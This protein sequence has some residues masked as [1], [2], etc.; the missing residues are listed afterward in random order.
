MLGKSGYFP[1]VCLM[2]ALE[3]ERINVRVMKLKQSC[4]NLNHLMPP[5][6]SKHDSYSTLWSLEEMT[7]F[8][9]HGW[10][11]TSVTQLGYM[12]GNTDYDWAPWAEWRCQQLKRSQFTRAWTGS[13]DSKIIPTTVPHWLEPNAHSLEV[14]KNS[15]KSSLDSRFIF[16]EGIFLSLFNKSSHS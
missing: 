5:L 12:W 6:P 15:F 14:P 11:S 4:D 9:G 16:L 10:I 3:M 2:R 13:W 7:K 1:A 8:R